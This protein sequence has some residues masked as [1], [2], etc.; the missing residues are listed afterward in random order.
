MAGFHP[1][2]QLLVRAGKV[3]SGGNSSPCG[4]RRPSAARRRKRP[5]ILRRAGF[6]F[7]RDAGRVSEA[8]PR[9]FIATLDRPAANLQNPPMAKLA[10]HAVWGK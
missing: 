9:I 1:T 6:G 8:K 4:G 5:C 2:S 10:Q 7:E 3:R